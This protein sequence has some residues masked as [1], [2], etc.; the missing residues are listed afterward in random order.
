MASIEDLFPGVIGRNVMF[1]LESIELKESTEQFRGD[2]LVWKSNHNIPLSSNLRNY[3]KT[4]L[5]EERN[6]YLIKCKPGDVDGLLHMKQV[7]ES[8]DAMLFIHHMNGDTETPLGWY[9]RVKPFIVK[10]YPRNNCYFIC[11]AM[12]ENWNISELPDNMYL[13]TKET[14]KVYLAPNMI[15]CF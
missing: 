6:K 1:Q 11:I 5:P 10:E 15:N 4:I 12:N 2:K 13:I 8:N 14:K 3:D 9:E 7:G